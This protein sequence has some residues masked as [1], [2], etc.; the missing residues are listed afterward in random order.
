MLHFDIAM[1]NIKFAATRRQ[2]YNNIRC[3]PISIQCVQYLYP[4]FNYPRLAILLSTVALVFTSIV[5][6][7]DYPAVAAAFGF[8]IGPLL[9]IWLAISVLKQKIHVSEFQEGETFG[10]QDR[11][12]LRQ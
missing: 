7:L 8:C 9:L 1:C 5:L 2:Q 11:P 12:D 4:M 10:Y 6:P 3:Y